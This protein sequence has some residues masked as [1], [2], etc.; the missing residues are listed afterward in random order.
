MG[1]KQ[2]SRPELHVGSSARSFPF[3][4]GG[5][6]SSAPRE[7][8]ENRCPARLGVAGGDEGSSDA[9]SVKRNSTQRREKDYNKP[10]GVI[11]LTHELRYGPPSHLFCRAPTDAV[12]LV[13]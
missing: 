8:G 3:R 10:L 4:V 6:V 13:N 5:G 7:Y 1:N 11:S 12:E 2:S 9:A